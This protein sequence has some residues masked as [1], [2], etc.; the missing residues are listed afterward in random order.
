MI[1]KI[2]NK[3]NNFQYRILMKF[4]QQIKFNYDELIKEG[5]Y[6]Q[7]GQDKFVA[8]LLN[9]KKCGYFVDI[10]ANDGVTFSNSLYFEKKLGWSGL[11]I[12]PQSNIF[13]KLIQ[14]RNCNFYNGCI[15]DKNEFVEFLHI[16]SGPDMLSGV[17]NTYDERHLKRIDETIK[18]GGGTK[19]IVKVSAKTLH[20]ICK[21]NM[22]SVI[23]FL[24]IDTE[25]GEL[26]ILKSIDFSILKIKVIAVENNYKDIRFFK[27]MKSKGFKLIA[28]IE[29]DEIY[30]N[31]DS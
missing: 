18:M 22:V 13:Q 4:T 16:K 11:A 25:G 23:D 17:L 30:L 20:N 9:H 6:S 8:N 10:G 12:E 31:V 5:Y 14:N 27:F 2:K 24:S 29:T 28:R 3:L 1:R 19:S 15:S 21:E 26:D 7:Y